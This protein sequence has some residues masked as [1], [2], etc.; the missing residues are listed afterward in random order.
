MLAARWLAAVV[1]VGGAAGGGFF[2]GQRYASGRLPLATTA[3]VHVESTPPGA[4]VFVDGTERGQ[5]PLDFTVG[6]GRRRLEVVAGSIRRSVEFT[7]AAG[8]SASHHFDF[9]GA[10][11]Q[12]ATGAAGEEPAGTLVVRSDPTGASVRIGG[13]E[14]G[15]TPVTVSGLTAGEHE[16]QLAA[17]SGAVSQRVQIQAGLTTTLVVPM[18]DRAASGWLVVRAPIELT[19]L[20]NGRFITTSRSDQTMLPAGRHEIE[21]VNDEFEFRS[22]QAVVIPP[23]RRVTF[24]VPMP[25]G[26]ANI[27]ARPWAEVWVGEQRLGETPLGNVALPIGRHEIV[28][29][30]PQF[31]ER[32]ETLV[33]KANTPARVVAD[34]RP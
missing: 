2:A 4:Q 6:V 7:A 15:T 27:N 29:R 20:E 16:V 24:D 30:H 3:A 19:L 33:I 25:L 31:G 10:N 17:A 34:F 8:S 26:R 1:L 23:G 21:F 12:T 28:F 18:A 11:G 13:K 9:G 32:R 5:T 22:R 14:L